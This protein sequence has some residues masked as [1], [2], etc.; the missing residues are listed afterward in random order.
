MKHA[1]STTGKENI[2]GKMNNVAIINARI[3]FPLA[4]ELMKA[5]IKIMRTTILTSS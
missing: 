1:H 3:I 2:K 4:S 5:T